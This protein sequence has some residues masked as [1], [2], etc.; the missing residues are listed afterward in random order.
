MKKKKNI[1]VGKTLGF[2]FQFLITNFDKRLKDGLPAVIF[3]T[4]AFNILNYLIGKD[5]ATNF[6]I[7]FFFIF[8]MI[9]SSAVGICV[10]EEIINKSKTAFLKEFLSP[11]S[12]KYFLNFLVLSLIALSPLL[13]HFFAR[14]MLNVQNDY[15]SI[16]I[17]LW[18]LT[19]ILSLKLIFVLPKLTLGID[20]NYNIKELNMVGS[21]L[22]L[23][24]TIVTVIFLVPS[25]IYLTLQLS[26]M[27]SYKDVY[28][29]IKP[30][31]DIGSFYISYL[32]YITIFAVISFAFKDY[33]S[34]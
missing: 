5:I 7:F 16:V 6:T 11:R 22:F 18:V 30:I 17:I 3:I 28:Q 32:N 21:K 12:I 23:L 31:F 26:F 20:Y 34:K 15:A 19:T 27:T 10:H 4:I 24:L 33:F 9:V 1:S 2:S 13:I 8:T 14:K 29:M 25:M